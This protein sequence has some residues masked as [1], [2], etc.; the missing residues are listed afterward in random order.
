M[1]L[2]QSCFTLEEALRVIAVLLQAEAE[3]G[4]AINYIF[5][6]LLQFAQQAC[7]KGVIKAAADV[8]TVIE[9]KLQEETR[10]RKKAKKK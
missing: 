10:K 1:S 5:E 7:A 3:F 8:I 2:N 6:S 9:S 4:S